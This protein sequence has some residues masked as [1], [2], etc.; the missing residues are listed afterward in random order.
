[1]FEGVRKVVSG[2]MVSGMA[3][4][5]G[6]CL[7]VLDLLLA[8]LIARYSAESVSQAPLPLVAALIGAATVRERSQRSTIESANDSL[9]AAGSV[10]VGGL[11]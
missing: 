6:G 1:M 7:A 9:L 5:G 4:A 11:L 8:G 2:E 10:R 3:L